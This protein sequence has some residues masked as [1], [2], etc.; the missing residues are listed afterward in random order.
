[1]S[2][3]YSSHTFHSRKF[4]G[5]VENAIRF[6]TGTPVHALP[7]EERFVGSGVYALYYTGNLPLYRKVAAQNLENLAK[8]IYVGKAVPPGW[9]TGRSIVSDSPALV[10]RIRQHSGS[11]GQASDLDL[12]DFQCRFMILTGIEIDLVIPV[13]AELIRRYRPLWNVVVDGF[14][15]HD[16]GRGRYN[17]ANSSWDV[18]HPGRGW[19]PRLLGEAALFEDIEEKVPAFLG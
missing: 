3:D 4:K 5:L 16:P 11:I 15:N 7:P 8:P 14:G 10:A 9:R 1:M 6:F 2:F 18:L 17:Q 12:A 13:E 19:G